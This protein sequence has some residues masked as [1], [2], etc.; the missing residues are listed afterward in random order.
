MISKLFFQR[1]LESQAADMK[2]EDDK[3]FKN[4]DRKDKSNKIKLWKKNKKIRRSEAE[5]HYLFIVFKI[6]WHSWWI[7]VAAWGSAIV[8]HLHGN[9]HVAKVAF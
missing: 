9:L 1:R 6:V 7:H 3:I 5:V 8:L 4:T 2:D